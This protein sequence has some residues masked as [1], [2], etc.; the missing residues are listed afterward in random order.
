V[1]IGRV[2]LVGKRTAAAL[3]RAARRAEAGRESSASELRLAHEQHRS[4]LRM[5]RT[6]LLAR[7]VEVVDHVPGRAAP[8][9]RFDLVISVGGDG[10]LLEASHIVRDR[11]P[12][13][14]VNSAP[15]FSVGFLTGCRAP[16]FGDTLDALRAGRMTARDV[17]RL[18]VTIGRRKLVEPVLNDV[19]F[20]HENPAQTTRYTLITPDGEEAQRSSGIW[21]STAAGSTAALRSAGGRALALDDDHFAFAVREP[22]A[23][24]GSAV[25]LAHGVLARDAVLRVV[26]ELAEANL[27]IDGAHRQYS[28]RFGEVVTFRRHPSPLSLVRP[29]PKS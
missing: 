10:T 27:Y 7:G 14:G 3:L 8:R 1:K 22:Y 13:L 23:P 4:S 17:H 2:L 15:T 5:V 9:G 25:R 26:C 20:C 18:A 21:V 11:T 12:V 24:P 6:A 29:P 28:V 19:L 16:T